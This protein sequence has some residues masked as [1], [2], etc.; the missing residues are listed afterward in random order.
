VIP[1]NDDDPSREFRQ[2][3]AEAHPAAGEHFADAVRTGAF[4][5]YESKSA[6]NWGV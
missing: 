1:K 6:M 3:I 4:C 2:R 5:C